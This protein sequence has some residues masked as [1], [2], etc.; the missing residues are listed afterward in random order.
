M[1]DR[2]AAALTVNDGKIA[3]LELVQRPAQPL[4]GTAPWPMRT[5]VLLAYPGQA[6][7]QD[8]RRTQRPR[9]GCDAAR[10]KPAPQFV[11]ANYEDYGYFLTLLDSA[12]IAALESGR[13]RRRNRSIP[14]HDALGRAVGSGARRAVRSNAI[15]ASGAQGDAAREGRA[16][17]PRHREPAHAFTHRVR[18]ARRRT[19]RCC[20]RS[21]ARSGPARWTRRARTAFAARASTASSPSHKRPTASRS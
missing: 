14:A 8:S 3:R 15:R 2:R 5:Q 7:G 19:M 1:P 16:A 11:F 6:A 18:V 21:S 17:L 9:D 12:S 13:T 4:S 20:P 10:G